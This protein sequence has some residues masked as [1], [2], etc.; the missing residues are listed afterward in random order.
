MAPAWWALWIIGALGPSAEIAS[1]SS[2]AFADGADFLE[3][4]EQFV[5]L[6]ILLLLLVSAHVL[7]ELTAG[8][9]L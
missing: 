1:G 9:R 6:P 8:E 5:A 4:E 2:A 7:C 3:V